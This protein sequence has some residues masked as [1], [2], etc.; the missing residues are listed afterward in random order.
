MDP[1]CPLPRVIGRGF[2][3]SGLTT[4]TLTMKRRA[5]AMRPI[6]LSDSKPLDGYRCEQFSAAGYERRV[7]RSDQQGRAVIVLHELPGLTAET[8]EFGDWLAARGFHIVLP[9]LFGEPLQDSNI[10]TLLSPLVCI[11]REFNCLASG[12]S[13]PITTWLRSL[14]GKIHAECGGP[15]VGV[16]GMCF[17][18]GFTLALMVDPSVI[19]PVTAEPSLPFFQPAALDVDRDSLAIAARRA[20]AAPL[21]GL[22][23]ADD[24]LC[25]ASRFQSIRAALCGD[26]GAVCARFQEV[27]VPGSGHATLTF[28]YAKA[29]E[30]GVD[31]RQRVYEHLRNKLLT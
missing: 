6:P 24:R 19:A 15:G 29:V 5:Q 30:R 18:G 27:V 4:L 20:D 14:C 12:K 21:L 31:T 7:F 25:Q 26:S 8:K 11:R 3:H 17:T 10:G 16:V 9:L 1:E 2:V 23:F 13:S 28:D 22:R